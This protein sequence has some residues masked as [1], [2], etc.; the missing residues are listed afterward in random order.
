MSSNEP[1]P[2]SEE[3]GDLMPPA[4][5]PPTALGSAEL[6]PD[7]LPPRH[8][9]S[10]PGAVNEILRAAVG[11]MIGLVGVAEGLVAAALNE[12]TRGTRDDR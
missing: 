8:V 6:P 3:R 7:R 9:V 1:G 10:R 5:R 2:R 4:R 11:L 12:V